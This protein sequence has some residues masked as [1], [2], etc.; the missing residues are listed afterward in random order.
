M[1]RLNRLGLTQ[2]LSSEECRLAGSLTQNGAGTPKYKILQLFFSCPIL[3][4]SL[5]L[6]GVGLTV[7]YSLF[8]PWPMLQSLQLLHHRLSL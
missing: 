7:Y 5:P 6:Y 2:L 1:W 3:L 4:S 8:L